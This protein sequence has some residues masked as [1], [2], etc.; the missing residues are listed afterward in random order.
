[1][2]P[3][4]SAAKCVCLAHLTTSRVERTSVEVE[5]CIVLRRTLGPA[6]WLAG[7]KAQ[8]KRDNQTICLFTTALD[9]RAS[10]MKL[11]TYGRSSPT[12]LTVSDIEGYDYSAWYWPRLTLIRLQGGGDFYW[13]KQEADGHSTDRYELKTRDNGSPI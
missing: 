5:H 1:V 9:S 13:L 4:L 7:L 11:R 3:A 12:A 2:D 8:S 6:Q 10:A